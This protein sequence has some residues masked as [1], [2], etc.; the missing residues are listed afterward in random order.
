M[1]LPPVARWVVSAAHHRVA[2]IRADNA[3]RVAAFVRGRSSAWRATLVCGDW[4][5]AAEDPATGEPTAAFL[6]LRRLLGEPVD[7]FRARHPDARASPGLTYDASRNPLC[8]DA[9][10]CER[11]DYVF[12]EGAAVDDARV[13]DDSDDS[14]HYAVSASIRL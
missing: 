10:V 14:D 7:A 9:G 4:N 2:A 11:I 5:V 12:V 8:V 13:H 3:A 6:E 1:T